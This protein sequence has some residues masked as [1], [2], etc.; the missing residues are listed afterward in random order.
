M[1][2]QEK[3]FQRGISIIELIIAM[4]VL[5]TIFGLVSLNLLNTK[6]R[7]N[8]NTTLNQ[9]LSDIKLQQVKAMSLSVE[10]NAPSTSDYG[11]HFESTTYTSFR[12]SSYVPAASGNFTLSLG[13]N[14]VFESVS[15]PQSVIIFSRQNGE[16]QSFNPLLN[17]IVLKN[18]LN[19]QQK[20]IKINRY[21]VFTQ[22]N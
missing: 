16:I 7:T 5:S 1:K 2:N 6:Q 20:T 12:G 22:I 18:T 15:L 19:N 4:M 3:N 21:G 14:M 11:I 13:D 8:F 17:T 10:N 9:L